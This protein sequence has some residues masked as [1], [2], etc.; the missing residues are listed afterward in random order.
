MRTAIRA[1]NHAS[2]TKGFASN[3]ARWRCMKAAVVRAVSSSWQIKGVQFCEIQP[4]AKAEYGAAQL[5]QHRAE[6]AGGGSIRSKRKSSASAISRGLIC[7]KTSA[8]PRM[9]W[10]LYHARPSS[11]SCVRSPGPCRWITSQSFES[12]ARRQEFKLMGGDPLASHHGF[13]SVF[14]V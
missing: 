1:S 2:T 9:P 14:A 4:S 7:R 13:T 5:M 10:V 6:F 11:S 8:T 3:S 12:L